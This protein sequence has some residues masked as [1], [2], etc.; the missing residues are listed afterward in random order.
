MSGLGKGVGDTVGNVGKGVGDTVGG[1]GKG[2]G[3]TVG[4]AT[5]G[6]GDTAKGVTGGGE[7][8]GDSSSVAGKPQTGQNPLGLSE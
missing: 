4:G 8:G 1:L 3:D 5:K 6:V 7:S 2:V